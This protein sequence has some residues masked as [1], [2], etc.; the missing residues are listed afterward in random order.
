ITQIDENNEKGE[1]FSKVDTPKERLGRLLLCKVNKD[2]NDHKIE[3]QEL[4]RIET[5]A[6]LD[7][8]WS[9]QLINDKS[10]LAIA[11]STG[12]ISLYDLNQNNSQF[13][14]ITKYI[15]NNEDKLCLSLDWSNRIGNISQKA[16]IVVSQSDGN[17]VILSVDNKFGIHETNK[18]VA[19]DFEAW[20]AAFN[21]WDTNLVYT[22]GDDC[23][24]KGW[25]LRMNPSIPLFSS[26]KHQAGV[27]SIQSNQH[28]EHRLITGSYDEHILL[29]DTRSMKRPIYDYNIGGGV[30]RLKWHPTRKDY[31]LAAC[32]HNGFHVIKVDDDV[33]MKTTRSFMKHESLAYGVDWNYSDQWNNKNSLIASCSFYDHIIHLWESI[34]N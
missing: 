14:L 15:T 26:K 5:A 21:Y 34:L 6:I 1:E 8:K 2:E 11:D 18:W 32:M 17:I 4:Q 9:H 12:I 7:M 24:F 33:T 16:S 23:F 13:D 3:L 22:G 10:I 28:S 31:F 25:D 19:H 29:W 20:I 27:C 30:W